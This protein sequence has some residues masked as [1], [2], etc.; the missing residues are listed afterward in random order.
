M[1]GTLVEM[2][3]HHCASCKSNQRLRNMRLTMIWDAPSTDTRHIWTNIQMQVL[4]LNSSTYSLPTRSRSCRL[5]LCCLL[6]LLFLLELVGKSEI[7]FTEGFLFTSLFPYW[8]TQFTAPYWS[9]VAAA[10]EMKSTASKSYRTFWLKYS[11]FTSVILRA[12]SHID[13]VVYYV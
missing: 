10:S 3:D 7:N 11:T 12:A 2:A 1:S 9:Q 5:D 4:F 6:F 13:E 8:S